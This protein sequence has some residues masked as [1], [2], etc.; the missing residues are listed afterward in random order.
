METIEKILN[1]F[2]TEKIPVILKNYSL[3]E[4]DLILDKRD[5]DSFSNKWMNVYESI[6][7]QI[8][9]NHFS[10]GL[11]ERVFKIVL[12]NTN[13]SDLASYIS[14]DFGL[15]LDATKINFNDEW[16]NYLW[17]V[18]SKN[19]IPYENIGTVE[20]KLKDLIYSANI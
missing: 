17:I 16:L 18:Y 8:E 1:D 11:R 2:A 15:F 10:D 14:D 13:N 5:L 6:N 3:E 20:G 7:A 9:N 12:S 19:Q 4:Y